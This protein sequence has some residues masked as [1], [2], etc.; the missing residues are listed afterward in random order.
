MKVTRHSCR[1]V[2]STR[3]LNLA[4]RSRKQSFGT[5]ISKLTVETDMKLS[6]V[7]STQ[8]AS[9]SA[10]AYKGELETN[11]AKIANLGYD[12]VE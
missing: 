10:L 2:A 11:V 8:P 9:F 6:I 4:L 3:D 1:S 7:L 12:G 5:A